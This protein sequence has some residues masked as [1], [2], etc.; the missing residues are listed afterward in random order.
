MRT[1]T[2]SGFFFLSLWLLR[3]V[4]CSRDLTKNKASREGRA[5]LCAALLLLPS[6]LFFSSF[7]F[8]LTGYLGTSC[9]SMSNACTQYCSTRNSTP[10]TTASGYNCSC[11]P[12]PDDPYGANVNNS[13]CTVSCSPPSNATLVT[14]S[15]WSQYFASGSYCD[16]ASNCVVSAVYAGSFSYL[17]TQDSACFSKTV[18][19]TAPSVSSTSNAPPP[20]GSCPS[21]YYLA[22][23]SGC[24]CT[25]GSGSYVQ[26]YGAPSISSCNGGHSTAPTLSPVA[27]VTS[28]GVT[29]C[30]SGTASYS[31]G[32][33]TS[34][35][36]ITIPSPTNLLSTPSPS[37]PGGSGGNSSFHLAAPTVSSNGQLT[38]PP[39][40]SS[41][42]SGN[43]LTCIVS[44]PSSST[45]PTASGTSG[46]SPTGSTGSGVSSFS[47]PTM[48]TQSVT[49]TALSQITAAHETTGQACPAPVTFSVMGSTFS[50]KFKYACML[51]AQVRPVV[52]GVFSMAS[53]LLIVK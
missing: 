47:M 24:V 45:S 48:P 31:S 36:S 37:S 53:L 42:G 14:G 33:S 11:S 26:V 41:I 27:P 39:G 6:L 18:P 38:C 35:Y 9:T 16:P 7:S 5:R 23:A 15:T 22:D 13:T 20:P 29:S 3:L 4:S 8:A 17:V 25:N 40:A 2:C 34:C 19:A 12:G 28:N 51:A 10:T 1:L 44:G 21:G 43:S 32:G 46:T 52:I 49:V 30:P 50:I